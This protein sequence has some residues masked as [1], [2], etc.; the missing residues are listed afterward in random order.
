MLDGKPRFRT[1][2][3][4]LELA[5]AERRAFVEAARWGVIAAVPRLRFDTVAEWWIARFAR[6]VTGG[7]RRERT[8]EIHR[9]HLERHLLPPL[10]HA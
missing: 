10:G 6:E 8:L 7:E 1:L 3:Y 5:R 2:G 9:Y 4:D